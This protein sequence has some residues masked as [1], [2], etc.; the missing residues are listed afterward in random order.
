[1]SG[2]SRQLPAGIDLSAYR[3]VQEALTNV[4]RHSRG[5]RAQVLL[6]YDH[7]EIGIEV[8][9]DGHASRTRDREDSGCWAC[10][11]EWRSSVA[12][13]MPARGPTVGSRSTSIFRPEEVRPMSFGVWWVMTKRW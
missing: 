2:D 4:L 5:A 3:V 6:S 8:T 10:G 13:L 9:D 1:M 12:A 7:D 11:S